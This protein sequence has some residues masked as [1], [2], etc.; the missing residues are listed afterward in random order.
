MAVDCPC[1]GKRSIV[2]ACGE[3]YAVPVHPDNV[4]GGAHVVRV[5]DQDFLWLPVGVHVE[6]YVT[7]EPSG[8]QLSGVIYGLLHPR[9]LVGLHLSYLLVDDLIQ[10]VICIAK[11]DGVVPLEKHVVIRL[12]YLCLYINTEGRNHHGNLVAHLH[13]LKRGDVL[14]F[15]SVPQGDKGNLDAV[16]ELP[17]F[18]VCHICL[19]LGSQLVLCGCFLP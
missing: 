17:P 6:Y 12:D 4:H 5:H 19:C 2:A 3:A 10:G 8:Y 13:P 9:G 16:L 15:L 14:V 11:G 1:R 18:I 7:P